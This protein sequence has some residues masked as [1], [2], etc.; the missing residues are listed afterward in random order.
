MELVLALH[1]K[2]HLRV[3][4]DD[5]ESHIADL[6]PL[7]LQNE[8]AINKAIEAD[9][10]A[11]GKHL[12]QVLFPSGSFAY[13]TLAEMPE[14]LLLVA[15]DPQVDA[16]PWEYVYG[17]F[18]TDDPSSPD[19]AENF[20]VLECRFVRGLPPSQRIAP[21]TLDQSLHIIAVPLILTRIYGDPKH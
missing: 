15:P 13:Q 20:L 5:H 12:Y 10:R 6:H 1:E 2:T 14:R 9:P 7:L 19:Y 16:I 3:I 4:C 21:P 17:S 8:E 11:Y 18:G